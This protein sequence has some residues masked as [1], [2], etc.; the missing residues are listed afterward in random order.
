MWGVEGG[1]EYLGRYGMHYGELSE[2][3]FASFGGEK[4]RRRTSPPDSLIKLLMEIMGENDP[5]KAYKKFVELPVHERDVVM[6]KLDDKVSKILR[7]YERKYYESGYEIGEESA[8]YLKE[9]LYLDEN[10][11]PQAPVYTREDMNII[12]SFINYMSTHIFNV[13]YKNLDEI[14]NTFKKLKASGYSS[15]AEF[16]SW[17]YHLAFTETIDYLIKERMLK[18]PP[19]GYEYWIWKK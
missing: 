10:L 9:W 15:F 16:F 2:Y 11:N 19:Y 7:E 1:M 6:K 3:G 13:I 12:D 14:Q 17:F 18:Q 5:S 4:E 8:K